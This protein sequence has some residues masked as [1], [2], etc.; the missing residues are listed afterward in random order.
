[1]KVPT[2]EKT[3]LRIREALFRGNK[4]KAIKIYREISGLGLPEAKDAVEALDMELRI[5]SPEKFKALTMSHI[6]RL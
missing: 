6:T 2:P 3:A 1:M 4:L 5:E